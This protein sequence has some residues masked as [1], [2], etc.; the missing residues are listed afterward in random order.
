MIFR[1]L[2][3]CYILA[4]KVSQFYLSFSF[5]FLKGIILQFIIEFYFVALLF[6]FNFV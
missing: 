4:A 2:F 6:T 3:L 5:P 1:H